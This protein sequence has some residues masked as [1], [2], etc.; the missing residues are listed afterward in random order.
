MGKKERAKRERNQKTSRGSRAARAARAGRG[1]PKWAALGGGGLLVLLVVGW[2][3]WGVLNDGGSSVSGTNPYSY[4]SAPPAHGSATAPVDITVYEDFHCTACGH[5]ET[6]I[7]P[8]LEDRF[9]ETG[10]ARFV[11]RHF[12]HYGPDSE[13]A[14]Q[15]AEC[16]HE[17]DQAN[18]TQLFSQFKTTLFRNQ[19]GYNDESFTLEKLTGYAREVGVNHIEAFR[20]CVDSDRYADKIQESTQEIRAQGARGT[21]TITVAGQMFTGVPSMEQFDRAISAQAR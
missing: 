7:A 21:P 14:A 17:Q 12:V 11:F 5:F 13:R 18:G 8:Q 6:Q 3:G 19:G 1:W 20:V 15:A 2:I 9:V 10:E 4:I 16:V